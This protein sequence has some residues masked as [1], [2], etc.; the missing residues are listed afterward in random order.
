MTGNKVTKPLSIELV[1][2]G[3]WFKNLRNMLPEEKW[4]KLRRA[5]YLRVAYKC[6]I[7]GGVGPTH[8]VECH[9]RWEYDDEKHI[10]TLAGLYGLCPACHECKHIGLTQ[11]KGRLPQALQHLAVVNNITEA[12]AERMVRDAF[13]IWKARSKHAWTIHIRDFGT[14]SKEE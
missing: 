10:A 9:E 11:L 3:A 1:P 6:E 8:P 12:E 13:Q 2:R 14:P 4:N 5:T 7:C